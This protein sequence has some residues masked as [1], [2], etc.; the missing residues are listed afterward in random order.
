[1]KQAHKANAPLLTMRRPMLRAGVVTV[2]VLLSSA[3]LPVVSASSSVGSLTLHGALGLPAGA[4]MTANVLALIDNLPANLNQLDASAPGVTFCTEELQTVE[5]SRPLPPALVPAQPQHREACFP[6]SAFSMSLVGSV[7]GSPEGTA[8]F[9][10]IHTAPGAEAQWISPETSETTPTG[11]ATYA[12]GHILAGKGDANSP[13]Y[14]QPV[15]SDHL[16]CEP[17]G[18]IHYR[19]AGELRFM[20][21]TVHVSAKENATTYETGVNVTSL[22]PGVVER[23]FR[24]AVVR[25]DAAAIS[26]TTSAPIIVAAADVPALAWTGRASFTA[27]AGALHASGVDYAPASTTAPAFLEG[28][29][30]GSLHPADA[31]NA[32]LQ[33]AG[34]LRGTSLQGRAVAPDPLRDSRPAWAALVIVGAGAVLVGG[35][36]VVVERRQRVRPRP[37]RVAK[38]A[39]LAREATRLAEEDGEWAGALGEI[40]RALRL[41][42]SGAYHFEEGRILKALGSLHEAREAFAMAARWLV[43]GEAEMKAADCALLLGELDDAARWLVRALDRPTLDARVLA[44]IATEKRFAPVR[45]RENVQEALQGALLRQEARGWPGVDY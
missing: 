30:T 25:F 28:R 38:A 15:P 11:P 8:Y 12:S 35:V 36:V 23:T 17:D 9:I 22:G 10:G 44:W 21:P 14:W 43:D 20:G 18:T 6:Y 32:T 4:N 2:L 31:Q 19:G 3:L 37:R 16:L 41:V 42:P 34:D 26:L 13:A 5:T 39:A 7:P 1:M 33:F 27:N 29:F 24:W 45:G 40:R